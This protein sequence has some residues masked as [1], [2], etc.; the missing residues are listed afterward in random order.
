MTEGR[1]LWNR[2]FQISVWTIPL[3]VPL[4]MYQSLNK[5]RKSGGFYRLKTHNANGPTGRFEVCP[6]LG[7]FRF[8]NKFYVCSKEQKRP[9]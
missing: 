5:T 6:T 8:F 7:I 3:R 4:R 9:V 1:G 2:F